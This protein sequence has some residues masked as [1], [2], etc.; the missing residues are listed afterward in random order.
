MFKT[1]KIICYHSLNSARCVPLFG[2]NIGPVA[3][4]LSQVLL[5]IPANLPMEA[6]L[7]NV[8]PIEILVEV[9]P[10]LGLILNDN[11]VG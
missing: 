9:G 5:Y 2:R 11:Q 6:S 1:S 3:C 7:N 4:L 10:L 8:L